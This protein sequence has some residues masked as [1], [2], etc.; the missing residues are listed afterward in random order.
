MKPKFTPG[1]WVVRNLEDVSSSFDVVEEKDREILN[2]KRICSFWAPSKE[3]VGQNK[4]GNAIY[5]RTPEAEQ[6]YQ[7]N[8]TNAY[9]IAAAPE[10]YD[11]VEEIASYMDCKCTAMDDYGYCVHDKARQALKKAR[12]EQ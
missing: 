4:H 3:I 8:I 1:P 2:P 6:H 7:Q 5:D 9:L 12:G 10:M 11:V